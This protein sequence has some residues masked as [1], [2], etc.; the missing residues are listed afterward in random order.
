[1][2]IIYSLLLATLGAAPVMADVSVSV[3]WQGQPT[4]TM[5]HPQSM[6]LSDALLNSAVSQYDNY[7]PVA[8][9]STPARQKD[10][11]YQQQAVLKDLSLLAT[12]WQQHDEAELAHAAL[13]LNQQLQQLHLTGRFELPVD[14]DISLAPSGANPV[15]QGDYQ[16]YLAPRRSQIYLAGLIGRPGE[17]PVLPAAGLREYWKK[18]DRLSGSDDTGAYLISPSGKSE[19]IPVA[20][21]NERHVEAM[22]GAT[23]FVGFAPSVLPEQYKDLNTRMLTLLANRMPK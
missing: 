13:Q 14:P 10:I 22:P 3:W 5:T 16:L 20:I 9:I 17:A 18:L 21:W 2:K 7:W 4:A 11:E 23:L 12:Y 8:H 6:L 19:W 1:M 15:L